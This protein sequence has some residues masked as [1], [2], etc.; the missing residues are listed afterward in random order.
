MIDRYY[1]KGSCQKYECLFS[2]HDN[3]PPAKSCSLEVKRLQKTQLLHLFASHF[4][5]SKNGR[6][7]NNSLLMSRRWS[8]GNLT[9]NFAFF[10]VN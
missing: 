8:P 3:S 5:H 10:W 2:F 4:G 6:G 9:L 7:R 1:G